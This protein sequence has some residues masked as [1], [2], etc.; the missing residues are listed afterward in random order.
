LISHF[1]NFT[2]GKDVTA[3]AVSEPNRNSTVLIRI[4]SAAVLIPVVLA[5]VHFGTP[6]FQALVVIGVLILFKELFQVTA[7]ARRRFLWCASG[8]VYIVMAAAALI[9]IR[10]G[11]TFGDIIIYYLFVVVWVSDSGAYLFGRMIGGAKLAPR[12]SPK[13]TWAGLIGGVALAALAGVAVGAYFD[14]SA[15]LESALYGALLGAVAQGGDLLE[16]WVKR[17]FGVKDSGAIIPGHGGL[18]DRVDGLLAASIAMIVILTL[19]KG[20]QSL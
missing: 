19:E 14:S 16:S 3:L 1:R 9:W 2:A 12:I 11:I 7:G 10:Q 6:Y 20:R 15:P 17:H 5:A 18:F 8:T 4:A 13:K